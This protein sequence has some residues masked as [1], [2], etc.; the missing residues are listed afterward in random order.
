MIPISPVPLESVGTRAPL[1]EHVAFLNPLVVEYLDGV[2]WVIHEAFDFASE[3]LQRILVMQ[4]GE[5]TDFASVPKILQ[6]ILGTTRAIGGHGRDY[7]KESDAYRTLGL[8]FDQANSLF[9]EALEARGVEKIV[10]DLLYE[11]VKHCGSESYA[12]GQARTRKEIT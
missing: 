1:I 9:L 12:E 3:E 2:E 10:M 7:G 5:T 11:A 4:V 6:G 8:T